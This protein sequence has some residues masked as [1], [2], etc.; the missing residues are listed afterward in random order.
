MD[1][2]Q[3]SLTLAAELE[4]NGQ[5]KDAYMTYLTTAQR[6]LQSLYG[7]KFVHSSIV[8]K[9]K[10]YASL[11]STTRDC[12]T[13]IESI[14]ERHSPSARVPEHR[15]GDSNKAPPPLP[16][17]P[18]RIQKPH[19]PPK[20]SRA[21]LSKLTPQEG[22]V[23]QDNPPDFHP[24]QPPP[25]RPRVPIPAE[26]PHSLPP[27]TD[28][29]PIYP[30]RPFT[31][32]T[33]NEDDTG[34][35]IRIVAE[36]QLD[37]THL[38]PAQTNAGDSLSP[39]AAAVQTNDHAPL[40]PVPPLLTT[41]RVLQDKSDELEAT[42]KDYRRRKQQLAAARGGERV[43]LD[44]I[45]E[46]GL[47]QAILRNTKSVAEIKQT[48]N[49]VRTLYMSAATVPTVM[50]F[51]AHLIA[52][53]ITLIEASVFNAIPPQALLEHSTRHP[54]QRIV[55]STD[56]FNYV[57]R[58]IEHSILLPQ[59]ASAR[60]QHVH[61]WIKVASRCFDLNNYQ[62]LKAIVSALG[63]PPVQRLRRTW[64]FIPKK[65]LT[66]LDSLNELMSEGDNYG[67]YREHMG[68][69]NTSVVNGKSVMMLRAEHFNKPTVPFLGTI[70]HDITYLLAAC[71]SSQPQN[72]PRIAELLDIMTKFQNG[73]KYNQALP[74]AY[75]KASQKHHFRP[76]L[77]NALH[78]GASGISRIS[79]GGWF[80]FG[81]DNT[82][83]SGNTADEDDEEN[84]EEQQQMATQYILMRSWWWTRQCEYQFSIKQFQ[85]NDEI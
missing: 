4:E 42:L 20:P 46:D 9:P 40:I 75:L 38:V 70:I 30:Q 27:P 77:S 16:P 72:E 43:S 12:L 39:P 44:A 84:L 60:A 68:M 31:Q 2:V 6:T 59:D 69:V 78:R 29:R 19:L 15:T 5:L 24:H 58:F 25:A 7:I 71:K 14:I 65:S 48:L 26:R 51:Q 67:R 37:P 10:Q 1:E 32:I 22:R 66:K 50:Q 35:A 76:A 47:N 54:H 61:Y 80:G 33:K 85:F 73:P 18:S 82:N 53:Q 63:T 13:H 45:S 34:V 36:G 11:L 81:T 8:S 17:K 64:A 49:R 57:T 28:S 83:Q 3:S 21:T 23:L 56:F 41:H 79:G 74:S 62:T 55:A 52:Y